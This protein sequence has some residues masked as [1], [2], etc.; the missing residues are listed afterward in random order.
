M[1][2][3]LA[4]L[5]LTLGLVACATAAITVPTCPP[6][7]DYTP[8]EQDQALSELQTLPSNAILRRFMNDYGK[9]REQCRAMKR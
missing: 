6:L 3:F 7:A 8:A 5:G 9:L 1:K 2:K 4:V